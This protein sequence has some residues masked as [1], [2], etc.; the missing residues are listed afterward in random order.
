MQNVMFPLSLLNYTKSESYEKAWKLLTQVGL[1]Q[2]ASYAPMELS[3]GQQQKISL[4]RALT[5]NPKLIIADEPTGN[6]DTISGQELLN[7]FISLVK[8]GKS[9]VMVTHDLEYLK[10]ASRIFH[11]IDGLIVEEYT[12]KTVHKL[13]QVA[14]KSEKQEVVVSDAINVRDPKLLDKLQI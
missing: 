9:I 11:M 7:T 6:M 10:Y 13:K 1:E 3:S 2:W 12:P 4:A 5:T 14:G 8:S